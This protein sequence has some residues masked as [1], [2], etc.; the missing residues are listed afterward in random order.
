MNHTRISTKVYKFSQ[1]YHHNLNWPIREDGLRTFA[2]ACLCQGNATGYSGNAKFRI[3][4]AF[5]THVTLQCFIL[6]LQSALLPS[7]FPFVINSRENN[8]S[9]SWRRDCSEKSGTSLR[10]LALFLSVSKKTFDTTDVEQGESM[11]KVQSR[12][13]FELFLRCDRTASGHE[14]DRYWWFSI[15]NL[16]CSYCKNIFIWQY[17]SVFF[18]ILFSGIMK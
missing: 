3:G 4:D 7:N 13:I 16:W 1:E 5:Y 10:Q 14:N 15:L 12:E 8:L 9:K 6:C 2:S 17:K 18:R 11:L